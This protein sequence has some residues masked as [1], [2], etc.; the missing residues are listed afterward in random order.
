VIKYFVMAVLLLL[1]CKPPTQPTPQP[2]TPDPPT[3]LTVQ[4][5]ILLLHNAERQAPLRLNDQLTDAAQDHADWMAARGRMSHRGAGGSSPGKRISAAGYNWTTYGENVAWGQRTPEEVMRV[6][7][8]SPPHR[9]NI[10]SGAYVDLGVGVAESSSGNLYW[11]TT[12]GSLNNNG[13]EWEEAVSI[14]EFEEE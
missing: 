6:W 5:V 4:D 14:P 1:G 7:V 10:K 2:P 13:E 11:C 12:F 9:R 8:A 3:T